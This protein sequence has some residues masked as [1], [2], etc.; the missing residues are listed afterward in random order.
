MRTWTIVMLLLA[1]AGGLAEAQERLYIAPLSH[2]SPGVVSSV[3]AQCA[4][5]L[6][7]TQLT[8][9]LTQTGVRLRMTP[10]EAAQKLDET[11]RD[12]QRATAAD[13]A[14]GRR[15]WCAMRA[16]AREAVGAPDLRAA[17]RAYGIRLLDVLTRVCEEPTAENVS[18]FARLQLDKETKTCRV[19]THAY[20][21]TF[22][23]QPTGIWVSYSGPAEPSGVA[24]L[25]TLEPDDRQAKAPVLW[26][27][28][29]QQ[30]PAGGNAPAPP[31]PTEGPQV[32]SWRAPVKTLAC[33]FI[34]FG[35]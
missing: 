29:S 19:W 10:E 1:V 21:E 23:R 15:E 33:E 22:V 16:R 31:P 9:D 2:A 3:S 11:T 27:Y 35:S 20:R 5:E 8:C 6:N 34:E 30:I 26:T 28:R 4:R 24:V 7:D 32:F 17:T 14:R 25:S 13:L 18:A 12:L